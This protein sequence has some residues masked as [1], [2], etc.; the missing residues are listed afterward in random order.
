MPLVEALPSDVRETDGL[1]VKHLRKEFPVS[2]QEEPVVAVADLNITMLEGHITALLGHNGAGK[3]TA[4]SMLT[5][6][7]EPSAGGASFKG[8]TTQDMDAFRKQCTLG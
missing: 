3:T 4:I 5:G 7:I 1:V 2:G 8:C 6:L